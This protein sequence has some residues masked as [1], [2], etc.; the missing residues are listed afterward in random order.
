[1]REAIVAILLVLAAAVGLVGALGASLLGD[2]WARLHYTGPPAFAS[3]LLAVAFA[4]E[5]GAAVA[6]EKAILLAVLLLVSSSVSVQAL[7]RAT[8]TVHR[9]ERER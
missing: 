4:V 3:V 8:R 7:A 6:T 2:P 1:M 5:L 9:A